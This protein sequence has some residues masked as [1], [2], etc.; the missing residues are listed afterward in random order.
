[1]ALTEELARLICESF[2]YFRISLDAASP[3]LYLKTHGMPEA[4]FQKTVENI[5]LFSRVKAEENSP[6]SFG[7]GFLT[8]RDTAAEMEDLYVWSGTAARILRSSGPLPGTCMMSRR[9][10]CG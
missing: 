6:V 1:M 9:N 3:E 4:A 5:K 10:I 2:E 8:S 7:V